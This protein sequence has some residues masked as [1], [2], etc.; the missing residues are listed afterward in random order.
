MAGEYEARDWLQKKVFY[1][2]VKLE[3]NIVQAR[4]GGADIYCKPFVVEVKRCE[5]LQFDNWWIQVNRAAKESELIPVVMFR[6]NTKPWDF[7]ISAQQIGCKSGWLHI[8][9]VSFIRWSKQYVL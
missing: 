5:K 8:S 9:Q 4:D 6:Q 3:R 2:T 1:D 7:L